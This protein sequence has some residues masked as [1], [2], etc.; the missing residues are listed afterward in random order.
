VG[1]IEDMIAHQLRLLVLLE[2][3]RR[4]AATPDEW[5]RLNAQTRHAEQVYDWLRDLRREMRDGPLE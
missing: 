2:E 3:A 5:H 4:H 1:E